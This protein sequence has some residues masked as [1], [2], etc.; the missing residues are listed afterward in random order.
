M[1]PK[2][3]H[4]VHILEGKATLYQRPTTP[5][6]FVRYKA[7][8]KWQRTTTKCE[9]LAKAK[10]KAVDVVMDAWFKERHNIPVVSKRFKAVAV[11]AIKRMQDDLDAG[12]GKVVFKDYIRAINN[13]IIPFFG[14]HN[15]D[16]IERQLIAQFTD[17][18]IIKMQRVPNA[19]TINT[20]NS[21]LNRV[22]DT[23]LE[24]GYITKSQ[25]PTLR[26]EGVV[27]G[28]RPDFTKDEYIA[29]YKYMRT[30]V[31]EGRKGHESAMRYLLRD[32][33]LILVNTGIRAGTEAMNLKW[34][35]IVFFVESNKHYLS[36]N[37]NG[38]TK[39]RELTVRHRVARYLQRIQQRNPALNKMT[40]EELINKGS[41][42]YVFR[43]NSKDATTAFGR[44]F[45]RLL[46]ASDL[47]VDRRTDTERTLYSLRHVYTTL[48][49][50]NTTMT[51]HV[52][53]KHMGTSE[54]M[55]ERYY[56]HVDM[57]KKAA[58]IAGAGSIGAVLTKSKATK[59]VNSN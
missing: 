16:K 12:V 43:V 6:W 59:P 29:L 25:V 19:S 39:H 24:Y 30:W 5:I 54:T 48:A 35:H 33:V 57:R 34:K 56:G 37:V 47:L 32:Y 8:G 11:L 20:H 38:K 46:I 27:S 36:F 3:A 26:N 17:W 58:E 9:D 28:R 50:T 13:Y 7:D 44:M 15:I 10:L 18:R 31:K 40:F 45:K 51:T 2:S 1:P 22:F 52:L 55:I 53:A 4:T 49:L 42:E 23:A 14:L 21:A 41:E